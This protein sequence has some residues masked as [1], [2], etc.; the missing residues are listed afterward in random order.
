MQH[1]VVPNKSSQIQLQLQRN[2]SGS[3]KPELEQELEPGLER[4]QARLPFG[5]Y[6]HGLLFRELPPFPIWLVFFWWWAAS[7]KVLFTLQAERTA[8]RVAR[9]RRMAQP[10]NP[11]FFDSSPPPAL[12]RCADAGATIN[13]L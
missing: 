9:A 6:R 5:R 11:K 10:H 3:S 8:W 1:F 13:Y 2:A 4:A 7:S 12:L